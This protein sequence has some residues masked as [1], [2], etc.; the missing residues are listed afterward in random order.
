MIGFRLLLVGC[1]ALLLT[2]CSRDSSAEPKK[3]SE[4]VI[5][6]FGSLGQTSIS[7]S[8]DLYAI[9]SPYWRSGDQ[10]VVCGMAEHPAKPH[11]R[12]FLLILKFPPQANIYGGGV[13]SDGEKS[14]WTHSFYNSSR[15]E[16]VAGYLLKHKPFAEEV[17]FDKQTYS[18]D[19]GR[20]IL[21]DLVAEP[22]QVTQVKAEIK[23]II[24][25]SSPSRQD[26]K[27]ALE[28]LRAQHDNVRTF[29]QP[30]Q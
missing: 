1:L 6:E 17:T 21:V 2:S 25:E 26:L 3:Q 15:K 14:T 29:W 19:A 20:V 5:D 27:D 28:K 13:S 30:R 18:L 24:P 11:H 23:D 4:P 7:L 16:H 12:A 9:K 22:V 10:M 8:G